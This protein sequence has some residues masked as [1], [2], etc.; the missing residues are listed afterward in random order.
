[1]SSTFT[2]INTLITVSLSDESYAQPYPL[3]ILGDNDLQIGTRACF[4]DQHIR[5]FACL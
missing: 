3:T 2:E 4:I 1:M 5:L